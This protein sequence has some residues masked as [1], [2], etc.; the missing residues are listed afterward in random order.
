MWL[1]FTS[2]GDEGQSA[3]ALGERFVIGR[4][5]ECDLVINDE[6][7]SRHHAYLKVHDDG[8]AELHD[9]GSANG[10][11]VNGHRIT[12]PVMLS[13]GEQ[14]QLGNTTL[15]TALREPSEGATTIGITPVDLTEPAGPASAA[16][17]TPPPPAGGGGV[18]PPTPTPSTI[19]RIKLRRS[20]RGAVALA[21]LAVAAAVIVVVL[22]ATG[23]FGGGGGSDEPDIPEIV[24]QVTPSTVL[25][26]SEVDGEPVGN[27]TGW[28]YDADEGLI[29]T[30][31]HVVNGGETYSVVLGESVRDADVVGV[32]TCDDLAVLRVG[33]TDGMVTLPLAGS[34]DDLKQ[35]Q[36][37]VALGF[38][39]SASLA[40]NLT[41][42]EGIVSVVR[43]SFDLSPLD[44]PRYSNVIQTDAA[45]NPGNSG[46]PLVNAQG[47]LVG[48]N[49]AGITL[50]GGRTIQGQGYAVGVDRVKE[51]VPVLAA[52]TSWGWNGMGFI[53]IP[54]PQAEAE[55]LSGA[56]LPL[57][58]GLA[59]L[60]VA[61]GTPAADAGFG[62]GPVLVTAVNGSPMDGSLPAYCEALGDP[63]TATDA[64]F[65]VY[66]SGGL[67]PQ[68]VT[69]RMAGR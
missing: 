9:M 25:V 60:N 4:D 17:A 49:S 54:D 46:G 41:A 43:T 34:Q 22:V 31:A 57:E 33:E 53:H 56:G 30:N 52:G 18:E 61:E 58:P 3:Q 7:V 15:S 21:G 64:N 6:R 10:T 26:N 8:R 55:N 38:P 48:V 20:V 63:E 68:E 1:T 29:V 62:Q 27:G 51:V 11:Y 37:V 45:I 50:L 13:G 59:I 28:V 5:D 67:Q 16:S 24:A 66:Q 69:V 14:L 65:T 40:G 35:G 19:E 42:T 23:V 39:A 44:V 12:G 36:T 47:E 2:G 32:A